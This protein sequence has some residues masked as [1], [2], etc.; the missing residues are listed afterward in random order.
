[1]EGDRPETQEGCCLTAPAF[2]FFVLAPVRRSRES[3][4]CPEQRHSFARRLDDQGGVVRPPSLSR[5]SDEGDTR[6]TIKTY[7][8]VTLPSRDEVAR[9]G[10]TLE[11]FN[12]R[13]KS[14]PPPSR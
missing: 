11:T 2:R 9:E 3:P 14:T 12:A 13:L 5:M 10:E 4:G 7:T 6:P 8:A 1:M